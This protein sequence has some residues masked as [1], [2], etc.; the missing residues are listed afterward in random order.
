MVAQRESERERGEKRDKGKGGGEGQGGWRERK[1]KERQKNVD[2]SVGE[3]MG[4]KREMGLEN[5]GQSWSI[6]ECII[7]DK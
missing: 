5:P 1:E 2:E 3:M 6:V 4:I 7:R